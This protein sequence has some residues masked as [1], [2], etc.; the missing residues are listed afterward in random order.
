MG[1][2]I[3]LFPERCDDG[4]YSVIDIKEDLLGDRN[5]R[6]FGFLAGVRNYSGIIP[7][8]E[9]RGLPKDVSKKVEEY[10]AKSGFYLHSFS[11]LS[12]KELVEFDYDQM[13][14]NRRCTREVITESGFSYQDGGQTCEPGEGEAMTYREFLGEYFFQELDRLKEIGTERIVFCFDN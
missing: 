8:S 7:I 13:T 6:I 11:W 14:E 4:K 9:A 12:M 10:I 3:H 2:D 5:Y 1:C